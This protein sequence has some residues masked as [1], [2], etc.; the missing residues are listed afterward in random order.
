MDAH[1]INFADEYIGTVLILEVFEHIKNPFKV[2][3]EIF[4]VL[5]PQGV[6]IMSAPMNFPIHN[7]PEDYWR[8]TPAG[9]LTLLENFPMKIIG[10]QGEHLYP[11]TIFG[12]GFKD[13]NQKVISKFQEF[14]IN[15]TIVL[16]NSVHTFKESLSFSLYVNKKLIE[17]YEIKD[18]VSPLVSVK[19]RVF[20]AICK[21]YTINILF[22]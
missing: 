15:Y 1:N 17:K 13:I 16:K 10:A 8:F 9:F 21:Y 6:V 22:Q 19:N 11:H 12:I 18:L 20:L 7:Y 2:I 5:K 3:K 14:C 4:R